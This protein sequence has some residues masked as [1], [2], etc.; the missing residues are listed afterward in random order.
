MI[1]WNPYD[2]KDYMSKLKVPALIIQGTKDIQ[3]KVLDA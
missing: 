3:V 2:P 1:S